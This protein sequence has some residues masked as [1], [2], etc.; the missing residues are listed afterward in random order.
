MKSQNRKLLFYIHCKMIL[1][2]TL[3]LYIVFYIY[4][5]TLCSAKFQKLAFVI[6]QQL[7]YNKSTRIKYLIPNA[8]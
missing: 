8:D 6:I 1:C 2:R 5:I 7:L 4:K 3:N